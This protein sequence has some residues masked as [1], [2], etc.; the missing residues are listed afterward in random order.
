M[1]LPLTPLSDCARPMPD[2]PA[3]RQDYI[4]ATMRALREERRRL[5]RLGLE[6]PLARCHHETRY[7]SFLAALFT[8][9]SCP[10]F[11]AGRGARR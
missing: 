3:A 8:T 9:P 1:R 6:S 10:G 11:S 4:G 5:E 2:S 7:W